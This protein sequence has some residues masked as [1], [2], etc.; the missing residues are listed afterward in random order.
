MELST[1][2]RQ[3]DQIMNAAEQDA[4]RAAMIFD[5]YAMLNSDGAREAF[6]CALIHRALTEHTRRLASA[7]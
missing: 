5:R 1:Y 3:I 7:R 6:V 4:Q 2:S